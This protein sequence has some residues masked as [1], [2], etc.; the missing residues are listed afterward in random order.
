MAIRKILFDPNSILHTTA[1][2]VDISNPETGSSM[3]LS[4]R[5]M[6]KLE[7]I[8]YLLTL[9]SSISKEQNETDMRGVKVYLRFS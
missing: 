4:E 2:P 1:E 3:T 7:I 8:K 5:K 6:N 9:K